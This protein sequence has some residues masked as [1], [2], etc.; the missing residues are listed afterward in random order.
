MGSKCLFP[1]VDITFCNLTNSN[2]RMTASFRV[3]DHSVAKRWLW[4]LKFLLN[5]NHHLEKN[6]IFHGFPN[7]ERKLEFLCAQ[8]NH[9]IESVN[10]YY[11]P[12][13][14]DL[15]YE[16]TE[17]VTPNSVFRN[18]KYHQKILHK[19]HHHFELLI[20]QIWNPSRYIKAAT[21][22][23]DFAIGQINLLTHEIEG[24]C[25]SMEVAQNPQALISPIMILSFVDRPF[26]DFKASDNL[27]FS[28][29]AGFGNVFLKYAQIGK[30]HLTVFYENDKEIFDENVSA[31]C[32]FSGEFTIDW[33]PTRSEQEARE[34]KKRLLRWMKS[35][36][37]KSDQNLAMGRIQ[38]AELIQDELS[39]T[40]ILESQK[41]L[42]HYQDIYSIV[43][44]DENIVTEKTFHYRWT[45][46]N[47]MKRYF[48]AFSSRS[49]LNT[50]F[51]YGR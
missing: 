48:D 3:L 20:G 40:K 14:D 6:F 13:S 39:E 10:S 12:R 41:K 11:A 37:L 31:P 46:A 45:D 47:Y 15:R 34:L 29:S 30:D 2:D 7:S 51:Y 32:F 28:L 35:R 23:A 9:A 1:R 5:R 44:N 26:F 27:H 50:L 17:R 25:R 43:I 33:G 16:I 4:A 21:S 24:L 22:A 42:A 49:P 38:V 36:G 8:L 18:G 19:T